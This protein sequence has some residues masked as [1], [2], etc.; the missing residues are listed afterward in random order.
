MREDT[1]R[2]DME[3]NRADGQDWS[4]EGRPKGRDSIEPEKR[5]AFETDRLFYRIIACALAATILIAAGGGAALAWNGQEPP[6]ILTALG[7]AA[8]GALAGVLVQNN[9]RQAAPAPPARQSPAAASA[10][11]SRAN[12]AS[13]MRPGW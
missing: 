10:S 13:P 8:I 12:S 11:I 6:Q 9:R 7:S 3:N 5:P 1:V 2:E 4:G